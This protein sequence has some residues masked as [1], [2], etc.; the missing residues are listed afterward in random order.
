[1]PEQPKGVQVRDGL[2][3]KHGKYLGFDHILY[4]VGN[5]KQAASYY[6]TRFGFT[7]VAYQGLDTGSREWCSHVVRQGEVTL[8]F[9]SPLRPGNQLHGDFLIQHGDAVRDVAFRVEDCR[10]E[11]ENAISAGATSV[12]PPT[13][14]QDEFGVVV[15]ATIL[16]V[17]HVH[18]TFVERRKYTGAFLPGFKPV[19]QADSL[20]TSLPAVGVA[21]LDHIGFNLYESE[22]ASFAVWYEQTLG[23]K[24]FFSIDDT[25]VHSE[26]S[27][28][29]SI[30]MSDQDENVKI[31]LIEPAAGRRKSQIEEF[32]EYNGGEGAQHMAFRTFDI[33]QAAS[34]LKARGVEFLAVTPRYYD[35]LR[36]RLA[37][38]KIVLH[39][40]VDALASY[41]IMVDFDDKGYLLQFFTIPVEDRPTFFIE[42]IERKDHLGFGAN[43][44]KAIFEAIEQEQGKR[45]NL[46]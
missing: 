19:E 36:E 9:T 32:L 18:H 6:E 33:L 40:N 24:R 1:M 21:L 27:G 30:V 44:F 28:L 17:S 15:R 11:Y 16:S 10:Q 39:E 37:Q 38:A 31:P 8:V 12:L 41:N 29:R 25:V 34:A 3:G 26:F 45:G 22:L 5:S 14:E 2:I 35:N 43:N 23:F 13:E 42:H 20:I 7:P 46:D 4:W